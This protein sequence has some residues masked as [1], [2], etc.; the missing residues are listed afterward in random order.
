MMNLSGFSS[1]VR[2]EASCDLSVVKALEFD[3][4]TTE[5][6]SQVQ[7]G[8]GARLHAD[9]GAVQFLSALDVQVLGD[10]DALRVVVVHAHADQAQ[11]R[12][13][14]QRHGGVAAE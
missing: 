7:F 5:P 11:R 4:L 13:T 1:V 14:R 12:V 9:G 6:V 10:H 3:L 8:G 2:V